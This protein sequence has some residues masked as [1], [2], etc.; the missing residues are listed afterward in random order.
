VPDPFIYS[1]GDVPGTPGGPPEGNGAAWWD[2]FFAD[3]AK[4]C[5]FFVEWPDENLVA[6][7]GRGPA[8]A[9]TS[10]GHCWPPRTE[11]GIDVS[12]ITT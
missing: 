3:R 10:C 12:S 11:A 9:R 2:E 8:S 4:P 5:P 1:S 6:P 7:T